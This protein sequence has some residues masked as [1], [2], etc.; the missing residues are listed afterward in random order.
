MQHIGIGGAFSCLGASTP[1]E[2]VQQGTRVELR[3][4]AGRGARCTGD[5]GGEPPGDGGGG[6]AQ[7]ELKLRV[8]D[9]SA[10]LGAIFAVGNSEPPRAARRA[11]SGWTETT[12]PGVTRVRGPGCASRWTT[13]TRAPRAPSGSRSWTTAPPQAAL[14]QVFVRFA[15]ARQ[16]GPRGDGRRGRRAVPR[17]RRGRS[18]RWTTSRAAQAQ[19]RVLRACAAADAAAD[20]R[21]ALPSYFQINRVLIALVSHHA[22]SLSKTFPG[23]VHQPRHAALG[24][25]RRLAP[26]PA[27]APS[28]P[29]PTPRRRRSPPPGSRARG[30]VRRRSVGPPARGT[31][32]SAWPHSGT[33]RDRPC[34]TD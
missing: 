33:T 5:R 11:P 13:G 29:R 7:T 12:V 16:A 26:P 15:E 31:A 14:E 28:A 20:E 25:R 22:A 30:S 9:P 32:P 17:R 4:Q 21:D 10:K 27:S 8:Q 3:F 19:A 34:R 1:Q 23:A 18:Q 6:G 2:P 24:P